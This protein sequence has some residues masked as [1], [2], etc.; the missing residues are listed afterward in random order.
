MAARKSP[1]VV[2]ANALLEGDVI[3]LTK[4]GTW[5]RNYTEAHVF[6]EA[7]DAAG[8]LG[9]AE[10]LKDFLV[11]AYLAEFKEDENGIP[12]PVHYREKFRAFGPTERPRSLS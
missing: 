10:A 5:S 3:Y 11:G 1:N 8:A 4:D 12:Q 9:E 2:T 6:A 7:A